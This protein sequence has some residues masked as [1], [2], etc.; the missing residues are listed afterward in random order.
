MYTG[1]CK[2][3]CRSSDQCCTC[4]CTHATH[5]PTTRAGKPWLRGSTQADQLEQGRSSSGDSCSSSPGQLE[6]VAVGDKEMGG[7]CVCCWTEGMEVG[8]KSGGQDSYL[9]WALSTPSP[10]GSTHEPHGWYIASYPLQVWYNLW[11]LDNIGC[12]KVL[13][14]RGSAQGTFTSLWD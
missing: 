9:I 2:G 8:A 3:G 14:T 10:S 12:T 11:V 4:G 1:F 7:V 13:C 6:T 5:L